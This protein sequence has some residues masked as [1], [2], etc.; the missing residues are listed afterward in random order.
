MFFF[1]GQAIAQLSPEAVRDDLLQ[2]FIQS[3]QKVLKLSEAVPAELYAWSPGDGVMSIGHVYAHIARYNYMY[4]E[5]NMGVL[6][7]DGIDLDTLEEIRDKDRLVG[8]L[9]ES[10]RHAQ[11]AIQ[12]L[13]PSELRKET[14]LYGRDVESWRVLV[15]L[16]AHLNEHVGQSVAY[17]RMN[18]V[19]PPWSM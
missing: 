19:V 5:D 2:H 7:P 10:V 14:V 1:I 3:S 13:T 11:K 8:I 18:E 17:A 16:V 12:A 6:V 9:Q 15:Q 4:L